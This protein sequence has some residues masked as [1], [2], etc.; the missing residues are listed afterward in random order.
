ML[1][2]RSTLTR[3][4]VICVPTMNVLSA[5]ETRKKDHPIASAASDMQSTA[6]TCSSRSNL[7]FQCHEAVRRQLQELT[8]VDGSCSNAEEAASST[9]NANRRTRT[10]VARSQCCWS[11]S[12]GERKSTTTGASARGA[13]VVIPTHAIWLRLVLL[14]SLDDA[15]QSARMIEG[16]AQAIVKLYLTT[17]CR[18]HHYGVRP[19]C[20]C[21]ACVDSMPS[22]CRRESRTARESGR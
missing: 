17:E 6:A 8:S 3:A 12:M 5:F 1:G 10:R 4:R 21:R 13:A 15:K 22:L 19:L 7:C 9:W 20:R 2:V 14:R 11:G 16:K 18:R